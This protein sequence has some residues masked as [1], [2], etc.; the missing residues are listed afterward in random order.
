M[1]HDCT[2]EMMGAATTTIDRVLLDVFRM[3]VRKALN[4]LNKHDFEVICMQ[5]AKELK[6]HALPVENAALQ[7]AINALDV[8]W[9]D[10]SESARS[11]I[12]GEASKYLGEP[13]ANA[14][15]PKIEQTLAYNVKD[16]VAGTKAKSVHAFDLKIGSSLNEQDQ[17]AIKIVTGSQGHYI[18]DEFGKRQ[19]KFASKA[20]AIVASGMEQGLGS[21]DIAQRLNSSLGIDTGRSLGYWNMIAMVFANRART[22]TQLFAF[23]EAGIQAYQWESVL[24]EVTSLQCRFMHGRTFQVAKAIQSMHAVEE[25]DNPEAIK[26]LQPFMQASAGKLY[27]GTGDNKEH[28]AE[29]EESAVGQAGKIGKFKNALS[30]AALDGAGLRFPPI[31]GHC[32]S[33]V[34]PVSGGGGGGGEGTSVSAPAALTPPIAAPP[35]VVAPPK[36]TPGQ[37]KAKALAQ[38]ADVTNG[39]GLPVPTPAVFE[40]YDD[41]EWW[42]N[43]APYLDKYPADQLKEILAL[44]EVSKKPKLS[45]MIPTEAEVDSNKVAE[46]IKN[47]KKLDAATESARVVKF[48]GKL[49]IVD[50]HEALVAQKLLG[51]KVAYTK[52]TDLDKPLKMPEP[53]PAPPV[54]VPKPPPPPPPVAPPPPVPPA[55]PMAPPP[56]AKGTADNILGE[57]IGNAQGS[58]DG[59]FYKGKDGVERYVK[60]YTDPAQAHCEHL[61]NSIYRDLGIGAAT[62]ATFQKDGHTAYASEIIKD[63]KTLKQAGLTTDRAKQAMKGFVADVLTGNWDV[64]GTGMD[65]MVVL[66]NGQL[67][68]IDNGGT[69]L[70]RAKAGRKPDGALNAITEW[71]K[72]FDSGVNPY[73][74][75]VAKAAG[76]TSPDD[77]HKEVIDQIKAILSLRDQHGGW[78]SYVN[79]LAAD[80]PA[81]DKQKVVAMLESRTN[82]LELKKIELEKPKPPKPKMGAPFEAPTSVPKPPE[83]DKENLNIRRFEDLPKRKPPIYR[84]TPDGSSVAAYRAFAERV[85]QKIKEQ[86]K[87][88]WDAIHAF[89]GS[90]YG[91]IRKAQRDGD[92]TG[93]RGRQGVAMERAFDKVAGIKGQVVRGM[94]EI[95]RSTLDKFM[96]EDTFELGGS[97]SS[98]RD[99]A[100]GVNWVGTYGSHYRVILVMHV[101][102]GL[103]VETLSQCPHENEVLLSMR[104]KFKVLS[105]HVSTD[106]AQTLI[107][108]AEETTDELVKKAVRRRVLYDVPLPPGAAREIDPSWPRYGYYNGKMISL[109]DAVNTLSRT[110]LGSVMVKFPTGFAMPWKQSTLYVDDEGKLY[111]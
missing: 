82:R 16:L 51:Q 31:H 65:N 18:R 110:E 21:A 35:E 38:L 43:P 100:I 104:S 107:I 32:R 57:K 92:K 106:H 24:D 10:M 84:G 62:S 71:E 81:A 37:A 47:S 11:K 55:H 36:L 22:M 78:A 49:Y 6:T 95:D 8:N 88:S 102:N 25:S 17:R 2:L 39:P 9:K 75:Q 42:K 79:R 64:V 54:T 83:A 33:T 23:G 41:E 87:A 90:S 98:S 26:T 1:T 52:F 5:L 61:A 56:P 45:E 63:A 58:N 74:S 111:L 86:D 53:K 28:V 19:D 3:D 80:M 94:K 77:A 29:V 73:Y 76:W 108:E 99:G 109:V 91:A 68:R 105:R 60:F 50:G 46:L 67:V 12:I 20:R 30:D 14:I 40:A 66:K 97:S 4:P 101:K 44:N 72:F 27:Y 13:V 15:M 59:G 103:P 85:S 69:F 70:M 34:I 7:K 48:A 93:Q 89:T 96:T